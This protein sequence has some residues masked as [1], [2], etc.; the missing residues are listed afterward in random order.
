MDL[1]GRLR[2]GSD[3]GETLVE[4]LAA[5]V[6]LGIAGVAVMAGLM[7]SVKASDM[8]R[9]ETTGGAY[10]RSLAEALQNWVAAGHYATCA[11]SADYLVS[12]VTS[13][14]ADLPSTYQ[15]SMK[16]ARSVSATGVAAAGCVAANDTGVQQVELHVKS[17]DGRADEKL[18]IVVRKPCAP[19]Q[20]YCC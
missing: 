4:V 13:Q 19:G 3:R 9:K 7:L 15:L 10:V 6:I 18:T 14:V 1:R 17:A 8:H 20:V 12:Q 11:T 16:D 5:V 2:A